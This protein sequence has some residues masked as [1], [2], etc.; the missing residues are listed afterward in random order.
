M[1]LKN[2]FAAALGASAVVAASVVTLTTVPASAAAV[3]GG[4]ATFFRT[5][6]TGGVN[7]T[8]QAASY[9]GSPKGAWSD[10]GTTSVK[11][12]YTLTTSGS[13][14]VG[15]NRAFEL[16]YD[17]GMLSFAPASGSRHWFFS[18]N[19][20]MLPA[21]VEN[22]VSLAG[23]VVSPGATVSGSFPISDVGNNVVKFEKLVF[24]ANEGVRV[25]C[26]GQE[27]STAALNSHTT[28]VATNVSDS[29]TAVGPTVAITTTKLAGA[30]PGNQAVAAIGR[31]GDIINVSTSV[32][33]TTDPGT[34]QLC[35][36]DGV[37]DCEGSGTVTGNGTGTLTIP[38][39]A[40]TGARKLVAT[41]GTEKARIDYRVLGQATIAL[42]ASAGAVGG[43]VTVSGDN[44][45]PNQVV[46]IRSI[47]AQG[48][49]PVNTTDGVVTATA[50]A[51]GVLSATIYTVNDVATTKI[52]AGQS[53]RIP[54]YATLG[55]VTA[56]G[57][58]TASANSCVAKVDAA[59]LTGECAVV[60]TLSL[61][62][63]AGS[64]S[65]AQQSGD[66]AMTG[67]QL[68]GTDQVST[69]SI[70]DI[71]VKDY[72]NSTL[73]WTLNAVFSGMT[74]A[75]TIGADQLSLVAPDCAAAAN[76]AN[77]VVEAAAGAFAD[78]VTPITLCSVAAGPVSSGDTTASSDLSLA[79]ASNTAPGNYTGTLTFTLQ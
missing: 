41:V 69:G 61:D 38:A 50:N 14:T 48:P 40:A 6:T 54:A 65:M 29:F 23:G 7:D 32:F 60:Q 30:A 56:Y 8:T 53:H 33:S 27:G 24:E 3:N 75:G 49:P 72:R 70:N 15:Q 59:D 51:D 78:N 57:D 47:V 5:G 2:R 13:T 68:G 11:P 55:A 77:T 12:D 64:L 44:F 4:C 79:I 46:S 10:E 16:T 9:L 34:L 28:P 25:V 18:V 45:D 67:V 42:S 43:G 52:Q 21:V 62:V 73:G 74:G 63:T 20:T 22:G 1:R 35:D 71:V 26:S 36:A 19:G 58:Y 66:I 39:G 76:N 37:T 17:K 31:A